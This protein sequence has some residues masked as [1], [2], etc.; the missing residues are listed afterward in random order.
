MRR[1]SQVAVQPNAEARAGASPYLTHPQLDVGAAEGAR[2]DDG[3]ANGVAG[4]G[5]A[6]DFG[7]GGHGS[8]NAAVDRFDDEAALETG[9]VGGAVLFDVG[10]DEAATQI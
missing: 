7:G 8:G 4:F 9:M 5:C 3:E 10:D 2:E 1:G 6:D